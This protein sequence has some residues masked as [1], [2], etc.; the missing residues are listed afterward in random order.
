MSPAA[1]SSGTHERLARAEEITGPSDRSFGLVFAGLWALLGCWPLVRGHP[2][3]WW[4][5][6][7]AAAFLLPALLHPR[8][9]AP[10]NRLWLRLGLLL[11][12]CLSPVVMALLFF[13]TVTPMGLLLRALGKDPLRL[14]F[15]RDARTY[16]IERRPPGPSPES[17]PRQF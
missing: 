8:A 9:L 11:H 2:P 10:L 4:S 3:R 17:M 1:T 5:L 7:V 15:D 13:A 16:W 14:R 12:A 6:A